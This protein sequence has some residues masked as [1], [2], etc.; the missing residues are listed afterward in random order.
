[1]REVT[2]LKYLTKIG[3]ITGV[4]ITFNGF[5]IGPLIHLKVQYN[6]KKWVGVW[7]ILTLLF[8]GSLIIFGLLLGGWTIYL[9][10]DSFITYFFFFLQYET[11]RN[12]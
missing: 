7:W 9:S 2:K 4:T 1:V 3:I 12:N 5:V 6:E 10:V 11:V 8:H